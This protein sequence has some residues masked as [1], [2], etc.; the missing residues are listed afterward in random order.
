ML[1]TAAGYEE[2]VARNLK[3]R[4][5]A[6][7]LGDKVFDVMVPIEK[8]IKIKNGKRIVYEEKMFPSYV[9]VDMIVDDSSWYVVRNTPH[10]TG[11]I[12]AGSTPLPV[13]KKEIDI[14][15]KRIRGDEPHY[16]IDLSIGDRVKII[17]GP[18]KDF[19]GKVQGVDTEKGR[20]KVLVGV[21]GRETPIDVDFLQINKID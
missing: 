2:A 20:V 13:D 15:F 18:F 17:D 3:S 14:I 1:H 5:E 8:K 21:F 19:E 4:I 7:D 16:K 6:F 11:F 12:G 9:F 10:V